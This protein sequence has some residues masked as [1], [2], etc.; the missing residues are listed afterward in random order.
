MK[1]FQFKF[2]TVLNQRETLEKEA[3]RV[4]G[5]AQS[6]Y[7]REIR[8]KLDLQRELEASLIR[9]EGLG[10]V[11]VPIQAFQLEE[12]FITGTKQRLIR[13]DQVIFRASK[14]VEKALRGYLNSRKQ[15]KMMES[16]YDRHHDEWRHERNRRVRRELDDLTIMRAAV[17]VEEELG[18]SSRSK[19]E[20]Q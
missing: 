14:S 15:T 9:R 2:A 18:S 8:A 5:G 17:K 11:A 6:A 10:T 4:L 19:E 13:Q 7:Q 1:K 16:L 20:E 3:L 12:A